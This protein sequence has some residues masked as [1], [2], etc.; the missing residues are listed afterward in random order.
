MEVISIILVTVA[1]FFILHYLNTWMNNKNTNFPPGPRILPLIGNLH[2]VLFKGLHQTLLELSKTYGSVFSIQMG[3][4]KMVVLAGYD[5]VKDALV[6]HAEEFEERARVPIFEKM[7]KGMGLSFSHGENWKIMRRFTISTLRDFGMGKTSLEEKIAEECSHLI[8]RV[9]SFKSMPFDN[10][11]H[12]C[13]A[14]A[15]IIVSIL[16]GNRMEYEDPHF[17]RLLDL[18]YENIKIMGQRMVL[19][20]N[21]YPVL[22]LL[23][24]S[25]RKF[26]K[27]IEELRSFIECIFL[28]HLREL[29]IND[30]R[31]FIDAFLVRQNME[32]SYPQSYFHNDNLTGLIRSLINAGTDT[33]SASLRWC[34]LM[35]IKYPHYQEKVQDEITKVIGLAQPTYSHRLQM[36]FTNAV[37]HETQRISN[38]VPM[39]LPHETTRDVNFRGYNLPK[40][41]HIIPLLTSVLH[42][43][44]QFKTPEV[45]D[46]NNFLDSEEQFMTND[47]FMAFSAGRRVC[48]GEKLARMELFIFFTSLLQKFLFCLPPGVSE[49]DLTPAVGF[50]RSPIPHKMCAIPRIQ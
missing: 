33:T 3:M 12:I 1:A 9:Q 25:H 36:P 24:G 26:Q 38:I 29:D 7:D 4:K 28:K 21:V 17:K 39:S 10:S 30:Q 2:S 35:M 44:K 31:G 34:L 15:N 47:A 40:G 16:L 46:P 27:N 23:P 43:K 8:Q 48:V 32:K 18:I 19:L 45:F 42:D 49:V 11:R 6:N 37:I 20:Y 14:V 41:T 13:S 22:G 50:T 5:A